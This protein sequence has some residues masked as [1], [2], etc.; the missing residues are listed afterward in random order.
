MHWFLLLLLFVLLLPGARADDYR[1]IM[2]VSGNSYKDPAK[3]PVFWQRLRELGVNTAMVTGMEDP[4][5][6]WDA[7]F[8]YYVENIVNRGLCLK[9][10]SKVRNWSGMV[11]EWKKTRSKAAFVREYCLDDPQWRA[12][13]CDQMRA[14][15]R[16][17][18]DRQPFAYDIRDELSVTMSANPW[19]YC[20]C[21]RTLAAFRG[22]LKT[23]YADLA[24]LN[25]QWETQFASWDA[26][27]PFTT[28][29][30]KARMA[31]CQSG[32]RLSA[33]TGQGRGAKAPPTF[34]GCNFAPWCDFRTYMDISLANALGELRQA[35]RAI[36][37]RTPVGIEGTQMP[38]A[39]GGYDLHRLSQVLDW[40][41]PYDIASARAIFGSFM[42]GKLFLSTIGEKDTN[43]ARRR[44]WHLLLEGD[45]GCIVW[46]SE[47]CFD[48]QSADLALTEKGK[49]L[50]AVFKELTGPVAKLFLRAER[51]FDPVYLHYSQPSI[52]VDWLLESIPDGPTWIRRFSS[53]EAQHNQLAAAR[54]RCLEQLRAAGFSPRFATTPPAGA[55][56]LMVGSRALADAEIKSL[57]NVKTF[58]DMPPGLWDEH[59]TPRAQPPTVPLVTNWTDA[60]KHLT[61]AVRV[62]PA[63][64]VYRYRL[65]N[66]RLLAFERAGS[67]QMGE[68][69]KLQGT[70]AGTP[71]ETTA[72]LAA[73]AHIYDLRTQKYLGHTDRFA[74]TLDPN[75]PSLFVV[76]QDEVALESLLK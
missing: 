14:V 13:A 48:W 49:A 52:Q 38:H 55:T 37:P 21:P 65:G 58:A 19:D 76:A 44:L 24:A 20:F 30:I 50:A 57:A 29:E 5:R 72:Q 74:F 43:R 22:W 7:G 26:V 42:P 39:F 66:V 2:W 10:N 27:T 33:A 11:D 25:R 15:A 40:V 64:A 23:Q 60:V 41:E 68:D 63:A 62:T 46:W 12:S 9:W 45:R 75:E 17:H 70:D 16:R 69:L 61:P 59:G 31:G 67:Q 18:K 6:V 28:D 71:T 3:V 8:P 36:D 51:E 32:S 47:D 56:F 54:V 53:Y 4:Q 34:T 73:P 35:A 1:V